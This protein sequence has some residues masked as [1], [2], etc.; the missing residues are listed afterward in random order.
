[1]PSD[2]NRTSRLTTEGPGRAPTAPCSGP[3]ASTTTISTGP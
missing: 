2:R 3:S 1:M